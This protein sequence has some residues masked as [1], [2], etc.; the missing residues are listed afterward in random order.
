[1]GIDRSLIHLPNTQEMGQEFGWV[2]C[3]N[4]EG[5]C[6]RY[7]Q[8]RLSVLTDLLN[9]LALQTLLVG[10]ETGERAL[11]VE[12]LSAL[13][14]QDIG[15]LD[16]GFA[17]YELFARFIARQR[18]FVCRCAKSG[19]GEVNR[20]FAENRAG[21]SVIVE[22]QAPNGTVGEIRAAGLP[23]R[24]RVRLVTVRLSTGELEVL[25]TNLLDEAV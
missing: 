25:A 17:S 19:F 7:V 11:A 20:L 22:L 1:V 3:Q 15:I 10:W 13:G 6:G 5:P 2:A 14:T 8:G 23:E 16:R 12:H 9:R 21:Q 4:Q 24:I 18:Y